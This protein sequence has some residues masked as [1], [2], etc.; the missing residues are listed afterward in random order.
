[1][2]AGAFRAGGFRGY[3]RNGLRNSGESYHSLNPESHFDHATVLRS[4]EFSVG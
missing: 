2:F 4:S 1:M 3:V